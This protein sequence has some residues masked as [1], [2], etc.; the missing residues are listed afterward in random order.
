MHISCNP[1]KSVTVYMKSFDAT[2]AMDGSLLSAFRFRMSP[3]TSV[4]P[5]LSLA[6]GSVKPGAVRGAI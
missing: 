6:V 5:V 3:F 1:S 2:S 4:D